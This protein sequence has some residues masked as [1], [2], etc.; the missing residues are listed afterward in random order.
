MSF[1]SFLPYREWYD[2]LPRIAPGVNSSIVY[3]R[4]K[5]GKQMGKTLFLLIWNP[6]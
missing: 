6:K 4:Q 5:Y 2:S 1:R 3:R